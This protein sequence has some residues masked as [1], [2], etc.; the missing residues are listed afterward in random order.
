MVLYRGGSDLWRTPDS[1]TVDATLAGGRIVNVANTFAVAP[2]GYFR[3]AET[4][5]PGV[6]STDN[7]RIFAKDNGSGKTQLMARFQTGAA[8]EIAIEP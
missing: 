6:A 2:A 8:V 5:D 1:L 7:V 4:T 3:I